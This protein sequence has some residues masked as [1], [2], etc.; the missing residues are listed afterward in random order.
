MNGCYLNSTALAAACSALSTRHCARSRG[1]P[2]HWGIAAWPYSSVCGLWGD[3]NNQLPIVLTDDVAA[4][5]IDVPGIEGQSYNL[6]SA[7][8]S[9]LTNISTS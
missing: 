4:R 8:V 9:R 5:A 3:G 7:P 1:N 2:F 6:A